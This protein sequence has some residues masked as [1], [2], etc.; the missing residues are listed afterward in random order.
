MCIRDSPTSVDGKT[1]TI[2][3]NWTDSALAFGYN[4]EFKVV[5]PTNYVK[6]VNNQSTIADVNSSLTI[7]RSKFDLGT[8]SYCEFHLTRYGMDDYVMPYEARELDNYIANTPAV[9]LVDTITVPVY[10]RNTNYTL[11]CVSE[12]PGPLHLF[13]MVWEGDFT[14]RFYK[15]A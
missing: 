1:I 6:Q 14:N 12:Y 8:T 11:Q 3:G 4:F 15:R 5:F 2:P 9:K 13:S 7:H 10:T